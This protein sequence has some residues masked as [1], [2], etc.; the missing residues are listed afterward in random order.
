MFRRAG[1]CVRTGLM[2]SLVV[3][4]ALGC[5][6]NPFLASSITIQPTPGGGSGSTGGSDPGGGGGAS[7]LS[8]TVS[9]TLRNTTQ[10]FIHYYLHF[11]AFAGP[12][13]TVAPEDESEYLNFGYLD[14]GSD[15]FTFGSITVTAPDPGQRVLWYFH[16]LGSFPQS[17]IS[18]AVSVTVNDSFF[19]ELGALVPVPDYILF[20]NGEFVADL[21]LLKSYRSTDV[22]GNFSLAFFGPEQIQD[23]GCNVNCLAPDIDPFHRLAPL[24][25]PPDQ[26][27]C[28][29]YFRGS[30]IIYEFRNQDPDGAPER[31]VWQVSLSGTQIHD[32]A[33]P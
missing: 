8:K 15:S 24:T 16:E 19:D 23:T 5:G 14:T 11:I 30:R 22:S 18:P 2:F 20:Y 32:F 7:G 1:R 21:C 6:G 25:R 28:N 26:A 12:G 33:W 27:F 31:L 29:E 3:A 17:A 10:E 9:M 4:V 13:A